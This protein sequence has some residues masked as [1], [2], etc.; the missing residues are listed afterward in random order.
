MDKKSASIEHE[1]TATLEHENEQLI[2]V[3]ADFENFK[4]RIERERAEWLMSGQITVLKA[5]LAVVDDIDRGVAAVMKDESSTQK[6][7]TALQ[8]GFALVHKK[9]HKVLADL[10]VKEIEC[11]QEFDPRYHEAVMQVAG[12]EGHKSGDIV[13][14][15]I[16]GYQ[17]HD[18]VIRHAQVSVA[19]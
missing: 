8:E 6:N 19:Q 7:V 3:R 17:L 15:L 1:N 5:F 9:M 11:S 2:R 4:R 14:V 10:G 12:D 16:P 13:Q 18:N